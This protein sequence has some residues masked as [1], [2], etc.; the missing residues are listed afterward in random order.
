MLTYYLYA[1]SVVP[2]HTFLTLL[3]STIK[4]LSTLSQNI[5]YI[6]TIHSNKYLPTFKS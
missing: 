3:L 2:K 6:E 1:L 4:N 5:L